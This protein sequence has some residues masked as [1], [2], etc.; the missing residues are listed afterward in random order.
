MI[1]RGDFIN[2][3]M[4]GQGMMKYANGDEYSGQWAAG[5]VWIADCAIRVVYGIYQLIEFLSH[6]HV[7][8]IIHMCTHARTDTHTMHTHLHTEFVCNQLCLFLY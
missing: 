5:L 1:A 8:H 2:N 6:K 7:L 4:H 3:L